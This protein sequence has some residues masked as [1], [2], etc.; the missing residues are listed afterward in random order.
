MN[1]DVTETPAGSLPVFPTD[2]PEV[3]ADAEATR[4]LLGPVLASLAEVVDVDPDRLDGPTPCRDYTVAQLRRHVLGWLRFFADVL[5]DPG[6][7]SDRIDPESW[8]LGP[9][10]DPGDMVRQAAAGIEQAID[11]G[12]AAQMVVM[13]Q[14]RMAG[15]GVLAMALG[16]YLVHGWDL[17]VS[18]GRPWAPAGEAAELALAF[19]HTTVQPEYRGPDSGFFDEEVVAPAG[20]SAFERLLCFG[21]RQP[22]WAPPGVC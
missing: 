7:T 6:A 15:D 20:A 12:V 4:A 22:D 19:L 8:D 2:A 18:T 9:D 16:E 17:A 21:G 1:Q 3:F 10:D 5:G 13:T 11:G 14:A